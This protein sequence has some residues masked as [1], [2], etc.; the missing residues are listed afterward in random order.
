MNP[1]QRKKI[2]RLY[3][4]FSENGFDFSLDEVSKAVG[5]SKKTI[6][7]RY[8][9]RRNME[10]MVCEYWLICF[11]ERFSIKSKACNNP[12]EELLL[13]IYEIIWSSRKETFLFDK[14]RTNFSVLLTTG[15]DSLQNRVTAIILKGMEDDCFKNIWDNIL[16][17]SQFLIF[18][19][20]YLYHDQ[21]QNPE[22]LHYLLS[23]LL[24]EKGEQIVNEIDFG[25]FFAV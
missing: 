20:V 21:L 14:I 17:Y 24:T 18:G 22:M 4:Y 7:N 2:D 12:V 5:I 13:F 11:D 15:E 19:I 9:S 23:P 1:T 25:G 6:F 3:R 10:Q 16:Q 8:E